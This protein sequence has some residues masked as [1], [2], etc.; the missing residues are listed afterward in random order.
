MSERAA[1][2]EGQ[3]AAGHFPI[4]ALLVLALAIFVNI[5]I[6]MLPM[7]LVLPMS[8]ELGVSES[9]VGLLVSVF[10]FTVVLSS[11]TLIRLTRRVPRHRLVIGVLMVFAV[12]TI[13]GA[14]APTYEWVVASRIVGGLA[15]GVFWTVVGAYAAYLVPKEQIGRAV[16]ITSAGGSLAFVLG[17]PLS[18]LLGQAV[19]WRAS[20]A[21]LGVACL[22]AAFAVWRV[23]PPVD[24]LADVATTETGSIAVPVADPDKSVR[25]VVIAVLSTTLAMTGQYA[26]Y[27]FIAPYLVQHA[28]LP[29]PWLSPALLAYGVMGALAIVL[30]AVWLGRHALA[31][32]VLCMV[33]MLATMVVLAL[34]TV[35]PL[36]LAA[37]LVWGLAMGALP[38]LLQTRVLHASEDRYLQPAMAWY[39]TGFNSGIGA[40]AVVGALVFDRVGAGGLPWVLFAGVAVSLVLIAIDR[41]LARRR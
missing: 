27:T 39:T 33:L 8:R 37:V 17:L 29:E 11:T 13:V 22:V 25:G 35:L 12:A 1:T 40:G 18:T 41:A 15:H 24:H 30:I 7:G 14:F 32:V 10:A 6:E 4:A 36:T 28:G 16:A 26:F 9:A 21:V 2:G 34:S 31:G 38:P 20:F 3:R 23:L 5:S 19:G